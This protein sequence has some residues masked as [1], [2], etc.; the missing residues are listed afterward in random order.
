MYTY[1]ERRWWL[2]LLVGFNTVSFLLYTLQYFPFCS[3]FQGKPMDAVSAFAM[4]KYPLQPVVCLFLESVNLC[5]M[6]EFKSD[7]IKDI[8]SA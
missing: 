2:I 6:L 1:F 5:F 4:A 7:V 8:S 3:C